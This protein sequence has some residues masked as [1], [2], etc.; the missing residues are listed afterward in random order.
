[1]TTNRR[2]FIKASA[3]TVGG[4]LINTN[5]IHAKDTFAS[6]AGKGVRKNVN[7]LSATDPDLIAYKKAVE[8]MKARP[9]SDPTSWAFQATIHNDFCPHGNWFFLPWHRAYLK[10]F[11]DICREASGNP[12]FNLPYW[13]WT[14]FPQIPP[15]FLGANNPLNHQKRTATPN[16]TASGEFIGKKVID[17]ILKLESFEDFASYNSTVPRP[18]DPNEGGT[19]Q[20]EG[21]AH[22]YIHGFVGGDMGSWFSPL[23][24]IFWLH[25]ANVDRLW[26][27]W[28]DKGNKN[29]SKSSFVNFVL[30]GNFRNTK[31]ETVDVKISDTFDLI[32][33]GYN[34]DTQG[35]KEIAF[36]NVASFQFVESTK[37]E[38]TNTFAT[39][40]LVAASFALKSEPFLTSDVKEILETGKTKNASKQVKA[41]LSDIEPPAEEDFFVRVFLNCDYLDKNTPIND[42]HYVGSFTFFASNHS[43]NMGTHEG[44]MQAKKLKFVLD[45]TKTLSKVVNTSSLDNIA[46]NVRVQLL[47]IPFG[48]NNPGRLLPGKIEIVVTQKTD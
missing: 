15:A 6:T 9:A 16:S 39:K 38:I 7:L 4:F 2:K 27:T 13:D 40:K 33:Q 26:A 25:H 10:H 48:A 36:A 34:Y 35:E 17:E 12:D 44:H 5:T 41:I 37:S 29:S 23:D 30:K 21:T 31:G 32:K 3:L 14:E 18:A 43:H 42:P 24:P 1:M 45:I 20:L 47:P 28:N 8:V 11:E 22:N 46:N 19:G